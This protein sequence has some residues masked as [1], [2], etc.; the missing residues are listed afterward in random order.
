MP[1]T[2]VRAD[3]G[4]RDGSLLNCTRFASVRRTLPAAGFCGGAGTVGSALYA[5]A[6]LYA[7][8]RESG[9]G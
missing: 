4:M 9:S 1:N 6:G 5:G 3:A 8:T 2:A 7:G